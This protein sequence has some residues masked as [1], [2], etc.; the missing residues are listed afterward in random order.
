MAVYA[1]DLLEHSTGFV[2]PAALGAVAQLGVADLLAGGPRTAA[3]LA[4]ATGTSAPFLQR[5][6]RLLATRGLFGED[7]EG[8]FH[9]KPRG[10]PLRTDG[11]HS[12]RQA[13]AMVTSPLV[14]TPT[15]QMV[16]SLREGG[17]AFDHIFGVPFFQHVMSDPQVAA[18]F[19]GGMAS[20]SDV[21]DSLVSQEVDLPGKGTI[22]DVGGG[23]GGLLLGIL[24]GNEGWHGVLFDQQQ[25]LERH[26]LGELNDP[27]RWELASGDFFTDV[28]GGADVYVLKSVLHDWSDEQCVTILRNCKRAMAA[29]G[30]I[31]VIETVIETAV[32]SDGESAFGKTMDVFMMSIL[33]GKERTEAE[34]AALFSEA[35][36][37]LNRVIPT[38]TPNSILEAV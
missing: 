27:D 12:V 38:K 24:R 9:L 29:G 11:P 5:V 7:A 6:L 19:H 18:V 3:E 34:F 23:S 35:G 1:L 15:G 4:E 31:L 36:L 25:A 17:P 33:P 37:R 8:R 22:V 28:P 26:R 14:W 32:D 21:Y 20:I 10:E 16:T 30:R 13:L 2:Y